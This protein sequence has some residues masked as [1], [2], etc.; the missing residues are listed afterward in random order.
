MPM[1]YLVRRL[2]LCPIV[3]ASGVLTAVVH[4]QDPGQT[5]QVPEH[6]YDIPEVTSKPGDAPL[7]KSCLS[8]QG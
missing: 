6:V 4:A 7:P 3:A 8:L 2:V 5:T 1:K